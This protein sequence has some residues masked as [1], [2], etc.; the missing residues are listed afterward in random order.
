MAQ[1]L[2]SYCFVSFYHSFIFR[3]IFFYGHSLPANNKNTPKTPLRVNQQKCLE[4]FPSFP[5]LPIIYICPAR[6]FL[7]SKRERKKDFYSVKI[8]KKKEKKLQKCEKS[9]AVGGLGGKDF[10]ISPMG[11]GK[12][13]MLLLFK[14]LFFDFINSHRE[15]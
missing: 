9:G 5:S 4:N 13:V 7:A 3:L 2:L 1:L 6:G 15:I 10:L 11:D 12:K 8:P 14:C